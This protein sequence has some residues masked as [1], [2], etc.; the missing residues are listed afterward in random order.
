VLLFFISTGCTNAPAP[1]A[2]AFDRSLRDLTAEEIQECLSSSRSEDRRRGI[3]ALADW[4]DSYSQCG[5]CDTGSDD[6]LLLS[7]ELLS[8]DAASQ[9]AVVALADPDP[10]LRAMAVRVLGHFGR[11]GLEALLLVGVDRPVDLPSDQG[12]DVDADPCG[13]N[14]LEN[15]LVNSI[16]QLSPIALQPL[17]RR[18]GEGQ[19]DHS[20]QPI[21]LD[22]T[23][24]ALGRLHCLLP[25]LRRASGP[26]KTLKR[27]ALRALEILGLPED[28]R[29]DEWIPR[30]L[31]DGLDGVRIVG[32]L[33]RGNPKVVAQMQE[34]AAG[35]DEELAVTALSI[36]HRW[37][38]QPSD[39]TMFGLVGPGH[40][41]GV[42]AMAMRY[43]AR[44]KGSPS[45]RQELLTRLGPLLAGISATQAKAVMKALDPSG[46][47]LND[48]DKAQ[49]TRDPLARTILAG[50]G[51]DA[52]R[53]YLL[54]LLNSPAQEDWV[55]A[56]ELA[57]R[58]E[59]DLAPTVR[60]QLTA[61]KKSLLSGRIRDV[62]DIDL[63][64]AVS[65]LGF[66]ETAKLAIEFIAH[67]VWNQSVS[68]ADGGIGTRRLVYDPMPLASSHMDARAA[69]GV[70]ELVELIPTGY[71][72]ADMRILEAIAES[73]HREVLAE[74]EPRSKGLSTSARRYWLFLMRKAR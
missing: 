53:R 69:E 18:L 40:P 42:R 3:R 21:A 59:P 70:R 68:L 7:P 43:L 38:V 6:Y 63:L 54:G 32:S 48:S 8:Q 4:E 61:S 66:P 55:L 19:R 34:L 44:V 58:W 37:D 31:A 45:R 17:L 41:D 2:R 36:L 33:P 23:V 22:R 24:R 47:G 72:D 74:L 14:L 25:C 46:G 20:R 67:P 71:A 56:L 12:Y 30:L 1:K 29:L 9:I 73:P 5:F 10:G 62:W 35:D 26:D 13:R 27:G 15:R 50:S 64:W 28:D 65:R 39:E 60:E 49:I 57:A 11:Q 51:S 52:G 16:A